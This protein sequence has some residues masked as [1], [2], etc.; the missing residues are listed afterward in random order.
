MVATLNTGVDLGGNSWIEPGS[1][2]YKR[3]IRNWY[4]YDP[5]RGEDNSV[6][7]SSDIRLECV[8][9]ETLPCGNDRFYLNEILQQVNGGELVTVITP[10][11]NVLERVSGLFRNNRPVY[12]MATGY[13]LLYS[14]VNNGWIMTNDAQSDDRLLE[15]QDDAL[16]PSLIQKRWRFYKGATSG[17]ESRPNL[18]LKCK[19]LE[20]NPEL[21]LTAEMCTESQVCQNDGHC[22]VNDLDELACHCRESF[23]GQLCGE[24]SRQCL[25][26]P[27]AAGI[28]GSLGY[29]LQ[30]SSQG[31]LAVHLCEDGYTPSFIYSVCSANPKNSSGELQW[32][33]EGECT[34]LPT[35][36]T[37]T[38]TTT[39]ATTTTRVTFPVPKYTDP[40]YVPPPP[41]DF[42]DRDFYWVK[43][44]VLALAC[45]LQVLV[46]FG[47]VFL[48]ATLCVESQEIIDLENN[49]ERRKFQGDKE[50]ARRGLENTHPSLK[51]GDP[52]PE[53]KRAEE[54]QNRI[55]DTE[56][57]RVEQKIEKRNRRNQRYVEFGY[58]RAL[59]LFCFV[60]AWMWLGY[61]IGC[62]MT[63]CPAY[64]SIFDDLI[65]MAAVFVPLCHFFVLIEAIFCRELKYLK[66]MGNVHSAK[67]VIDTLREEAPVVGMLAEAWHYE[68]RLRTVTSTDANGYIQTRVETYQEKVVTD[69]KSELFIYGYW[70]DDSEDQLVGISPSRLTKIKMSREIDFGDEETLSTFTTQYQRF[71]DDTNDLDTYVD[72]TILKDIPGFQSRIAAFLK[73]TSVPWW[74]RVA[75]FWVATVFLLSFPY[76]LL[77]NKSSTKATYTVRKKIY[78]SRPEG[79]KQEARA[80]P[81]EDKLAAELAAR[82][83]EEKEDPEEKP[84]QR[85]SLVSF[86]K[87]SKS[88]Q[89]GGN[90]NEAEGDEAVVDIA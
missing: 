86:L 80:A 22:L 4:Y 89:P 47:A 15:V 34:L 5:A 63:N 72:H 48:V 61:L 87:R 58:C 21:N 42:D 88:H 52:T 16:H 69:T 24:S 1:L 29:V 45:V 66:N 83:T 62:G 70:E 71:Q 77:F 14:V 53:A 85:K 17:W 59:S 40:P 50:T 78:M 43:P 19:G 82:P 76:R 36:T 7:G 3:L 13:Y 75:W 27:G 67:A 6:S 64:G 9:E 30:A 65:I 39:K 20:Q 28:S 55:Y 23:T 44:V 79:G 37:S 74:M 46:P 81:S 25:A 32:R 54:L 84:K 41:I 2:P 68:Q 26:P 49:M 33:I 35:T 8:S 60:S 10:N 31:S 73:K 56:C 90:R 38:T 12:A 57:E 18:R 51:T 11:D